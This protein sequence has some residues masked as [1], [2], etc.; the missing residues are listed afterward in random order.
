MLNQTMNSASILNML[1]MKW[2][3]SSAKEPKPRIDSVQNSDTMRV[4]GLDEHYFIPTS[5]EV[6]ST[7][8]KSTNDWLPDMRAPKQPKLSVTKR[9]IG[10]MQTILVIPD[11][12]SYERSESAYELCMAA[13]EELAATTNLTQIIQLGDLLEC[14]SLS[15]HGASSVRERIPT[16]EEEVE[17]AVCDFWGRLKNIAPKAKLVQLFGNHEDRLHKYILN[18]MNLTPGRMSESIYNS[19]TPTEIY[20]K[21]GIE[22]VPYGGENPRDGMYEITP[23]LYCIHGWSF[24]AQAAKVHLDKMFGNASIIFGHTHRIQSY[25][26]G[27]HFKGGA[28]GAWSFGSIAKNNMPYHK[29]QPNDHANGFGIVQTDGHYFNVIPVHILRDNGDDIVVLPTNGKELRIRNG[30]RN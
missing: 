26:K 1:Q 13:A 19:L 28:I 14:G 15:R 16:Y 10:N 25:V 7:T 17:W 18:N 30:K 4:I 9:S 12:H 2:N 29:G 24:A 27:N 6:K 11:V 23:E 20:Q 8:I 3:E 5:G 21:M 22:V